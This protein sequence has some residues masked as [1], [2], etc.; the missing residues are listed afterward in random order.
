MTLEQLERYT[1]NGI[2]KYVRY[3]EGAKLFSVGLNTFTNLAK[4]ANAVYRVTGGV[5]LVNVQEVDKYIAENCKVRFDEDGN[6]I[7]GLDLNV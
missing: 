6:E 3:D 1:M 2:K 7:E 4:K 5:M